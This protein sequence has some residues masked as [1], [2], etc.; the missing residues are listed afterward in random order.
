MEK[1]AASS[2]IKNQR[3]S[4][5]PKETWGSGQLYRPTKH[6]CDIPKTSTRRLRHMLFYRIWE[7]HPS[8]KPSW[9]T[10]GLRLKFAKAADKLI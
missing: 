5:I 4:E 6:L 10:S 1:Q 8:G 3:L 2:Q 9:Q 7:R